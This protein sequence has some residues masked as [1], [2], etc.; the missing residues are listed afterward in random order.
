[1]PSLLKAA[2]AAPVLDRLEVEARERARLI[3][4]QAAEDASRLRAQAEAQRDAVRL[5]AVEAGRQEGL[6][7]TAAALTR[8]AEE[9]ERR[10]AGLERE[11]AEVAL[12]VA[13][14]LVGETLAAGP[15]RVVGIA[16]EALARARS[17]R[18]VVLRVHPEDAALLG[19][20]QPRLAALLER[21]PGLVLREDPGLE[22][23]G[24]VVE[25][26]AGRVDARIEA[27]LALLER[28][29]AEGLP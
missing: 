3:V 2:R 26:E 25:T 29:I 10:L 6:A 22:R 28:A 23:G 4:A 16:R 11:L 17:R 9:K 14:K 8:I 20:E 15:E 21:A 1:M 7:R 5:E 27:Q 13:R 18:E 19:P 24:V 12:A